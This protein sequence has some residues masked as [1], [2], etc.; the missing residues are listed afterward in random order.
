MG[1]LVKAVLFGNLVVVV[2]VQGDV[3]TPA[4]YLT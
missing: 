4:R 3:T 2:D 1:E